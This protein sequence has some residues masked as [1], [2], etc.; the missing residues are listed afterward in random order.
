MFLFVPMWSN[1]LCN[2]VFRSA[3][4]CS[5]RCVPGWRASSPLY[6]FYANFSLRLINNMVC[7]L[8][9]LS[10]EWCACC[11]LGVLP[12]AVE[13][14]PLVPCVLMRRG[15][16]TSISLFLC[17]DGHL[18]D[19][20]HAWL[21]N[22]S[23]LFIFTTL[24]LFLCTRFFFSCSVIDAVVLCVFRDQ[25]YRF[26]C[27]S[28]WNK[29]GWSCHAAPRGGPGPQFPTRPL[30]EATKNVLWYVLPR[31]RGFLH[32]SKHVNKIGSSTLILVVTRG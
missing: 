8:L 19:L 12:S 14:Q 23:M 11:V 26:V 32:S 22:N 9:L 21:V 16:E 13:P 5:R 17:C 4:A 6:Q 10:A 7:M 31:W 20:G 30:M 24:L 15:M 2:L 3:Y 29:K 1:L 27:A 18:C 25:Y 28:C